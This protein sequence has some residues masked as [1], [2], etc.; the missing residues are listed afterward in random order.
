M[1]GLLRT[2]TNEINRETH[3]SICLSRGGNIIYMVVKHI[4]RLSLIIT[5]GR[6]QNGSWYF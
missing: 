2:Q 4:A 3:V 6:F 1:I 5:I